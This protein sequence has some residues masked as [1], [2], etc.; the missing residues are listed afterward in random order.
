M[1]PLTSPIEPPLADASIR[2]EFADSARRC[3]ASWCHGPLPRRTHRRVQAYFDDLYRGAPLARW[4]A[5]ADRARP[6]LAEAL[7]LPPERVVFASSATA[8]WALLV[9]RARAGPILMSDGCYPTLRA[10]VERAGRRR[11]RVP[12]CADLVEAVTADTA[13]VVAT[14]VGWRRGEP[15]DLRPLSARCR[16]LGVPLAADVTHAVGHRVLDPAHRADFVIGN[17]R[18]WLLG[19]GG[20]GYLAAALDAPAVGGGDLADEL[21]V[22]AFGLG[23]RNKPALVA[24]A[25]SLAV[26]RA[27][28]PDRIERRVVE[29][30]G[31]TRRRA[32]ADGW[33]DAAAPGSPGMVPLAFAAEAGRLEAERALSAA[34]LQ[35][36]GQGS[37]LMLALHVFVD[38]AAIDAAFD[39]L[40]DFRPIR[41][42]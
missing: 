12:R 28:G 35:A 25:E 41:G 34:G 2:A 18:K 26:R 5:E 8:A 23:A 1:A 6:A 40:R 31:H 10:V 21:G 4:S 13:L 16:A 22:D 33:T 37:T 36:R 11:R 27:L 15:T 19:L 3:L 30:T 7:G 42:G 39:R 9:G 20:L 24:L 32:A 38:P 14:P 29:L 17:T